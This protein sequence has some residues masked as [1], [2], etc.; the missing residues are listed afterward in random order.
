MT[1]ETKELIT[2]VDKHKVIVYSYI[3]GRDKREI[4]SVYLSNSKINVSDE[5]I[6]TPSFDGSLVNKATD[7]AIELLIE[8]VDGKKENILESILDF[9]AED[10]D[11]IVNELNE[12][13]KPK[14][15]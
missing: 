10:Y 12:I 15:K 8:S 13:Q 14:K 3:T 2:P 5:K 7:K 6:S 9:K 11:F 1:R 4:T